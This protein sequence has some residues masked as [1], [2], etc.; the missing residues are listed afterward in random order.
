MK[1]KI[2]LINC[3]TRGIDSNTDLAIQGCVAGIKKCYTERIQLNK[4]FLQDGTSQNLDEIIGQIQKADGIIF[5][6]PVYFGMPSSLFQDLVSEIKKRRIDLYPK[7]IGLVSVGAKRNGGE[8]TTITWMAWWLME[9]GALVVN[10]GFPISQFGGVVV[11]GTKGSA[12]QD[13]EGLKTCFNLGR[14][15][16]ET[17]RII[18]KGRPKSRVPI[19]INVWLLSADDDSEEKV[20]MTRPSYG[21]V[22]IMNLNFHRCRGCEICPNPKAKG[23]F[24]C[25]NDQD[26][27]AKIHNEL[28]GSNGV[29]P[30]GW[31]AKFME[32]TRYLRRDNYR[33]TYSV[34]YISEPKYIPFFI[35]ENSILCKLHFEQYVKLIASGRKKLNLTKQIYKPKGYQILH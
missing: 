33:L 20:F 27:I 23:D 24:K 11:A 21:V 1:P 3:S 18:K 28:V 4:Y 5:G 7:V 9:L 16:G 15:V 13:E 34:V 6:S 10:D 17:T 25:I 32:R 26:D 31:N 35:K 22:D 29:V 2:L 12:S 30:V 8:E 14:R 19:K